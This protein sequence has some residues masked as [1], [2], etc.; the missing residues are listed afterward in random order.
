M[1]WYIRGEQAKP[2][3]GPYS[4]PSLASRAVGTTGL[5][6]P[7]LVVHSADPSLPGLLPVHPP[8][9]VAGRREGQEEDPGLVT[10]L[11]ISEVSKSSLGSARQQAEPSKSSRGEGPGLVYA[12]HALRLGP[13]PR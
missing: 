6:P 12:W 9:S 4:R 10:R 5:G 7:V 13:W 2:R 8:W 1:S 11:V 3:L